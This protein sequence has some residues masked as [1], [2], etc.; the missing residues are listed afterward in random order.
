MGV[1]ALRASECA[2]GGLRALKPACTGLP[3]VARKVDSTRQRRR[4]RVDR[5]MVTTLNTKN[6]PTL[7]RQALAAWALV[8]VLPAA[9]AQKPEVQ[10][11]AEVLV[12][13]VLSLVVSGAE[14]GT[15]LS[16][17]ASRQASEFT[18]GTRPQLSRA[19]CKADAQGRIDLARQAPMNV[20][21][22]Q[23]GP[24]R[25]AVF[26]T[27]SSPK[28]TPCASASWVP[29]RG[30]FALLATSRMPWIRAVVAIVASDVVWEG[31]GSGVAGGARQL[32]REGRAAAFCALPGLRQGDCGLCQRCRC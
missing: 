31:W 10:P 5:F 9:Q 24:F 8:S 23:A 17:Q 21:T 22:R 18:G 6:Q 1:S 28:S 32:R 30:E 19:S 29:A 12:G 11:A 3:L 20:A 4:D 2:V 15:E 26:A 7:A 14:P 13:D 25:G 16:V 27:R